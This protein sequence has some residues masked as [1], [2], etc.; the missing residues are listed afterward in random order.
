MIKNI[1]LILFFL[2]SFIGRSQQLLQ[3]IDDAAA[4]IAQ[5]LEAS[6]AGVKEPVRITNFTFEDKK[7]CSVFSNY[8]TLAVE[9]K[10]INDKLIS[11]SSRT[12]N[13]MLDDSKKAEEYILKGTYQDTGKSLKIVAKVCKGNNTI[14]METVWLSKTELEKQSLS[15]KPDNFT[16]ALANENIFLKEEVMPSPDLKIDIITN[17]GNDNLIF[18]KDDILNLFVKTNKECYIRV[19]YYLADG[20]KVLLIDNMKIT[21][22]IINKYYQIP[23][24]FQCS[25][26]FG[27]ETLQLLAQSEPFNKL[28]TQSRS[29]KLFIIEDTGEMV[30]NL[31]KE[32]K[33]QT[34]SAEQRLSL[35]K[36][37]K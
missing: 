35:T 25:A 7:M 3:K 34:E 6:L 27:V 36:V 26:P 28:Q 32:M 9:A 4:I 21:S 17:K 24:I 8:F 19:I 29:G 13:I 37:G 23:E 2:N 10:L 18:E 30:Q 1:F 20:Q 22:E 14:A 16:L 33:K 15:Y 12:Q 11:I 5:D 31:R